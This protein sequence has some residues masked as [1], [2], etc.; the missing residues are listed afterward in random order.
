MSLSIISK[1]NTFKRQRDLV[2]QAREERSREKESLIDFASYR[3]R[4]IEFVQE[5][6]GVEYLTPEQKEFYVHIRDNQ[7]TNIQ[8]AHGVGKSF[9]MAGLVIWWVRAV[10]GIA[11]TTAPSHGQVKD[12][13]WKEVRFL[14]DRKKKILGG[15]RTELVLHFVNDKGKELTAIGFS[16]RNYDSNSFQGK[17]DEFLLLLQDEADGITQVIDDAYES[18]IQGSQ[19]RGVRIGNPLTP[20]SSFAKNCKINSIKVPVWNHVN[21][22]WA[23]HKVTLSNGKII[24]R[25]KTEIAALILKPATDKSAKSDP[26]KPQN[27]WP[28]SLPRDRIP[29]AVSIAWIE[30]IRAKYGEFSV[31]WVSRVEAEFPGD[32]V[33]GIIPISWLKQARQRYDN[34]PQYWD[35]LASLDRWRIGA[36]VGDGGDPH[37]ISL[38]RGCVLY[39]VKTYQGVNDRE[40]TVRLATKYIE[41]L[42][43]NLGGTYKGAVDR[44]GVGAGTLGTLRTHG[45]NFIGCTFGEKAKNEENY[46]D[47]KIELHW[48]LR[49]QLQKGEIAIAPLGEIEEELFEDLSAVR[50]ST[51]TKDKLICEPKKLTKARLGRSPNAGD[52][53]IISLEVPIQVYVIPE[54]VPASSNVD[55]EMRKIQQ[56]QSE[57]ENF[58]SV[59]EAEANQYFQ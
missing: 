19:N 27:Q 37:A 13:L 29:G 18:C 48:T 50:Y 26:V 36:D 5:V 53:L 49:E 59:T 55:L 43:N 21:V 4:P 3:M 6:L 35:N 31:Y 46:Q 24:H 44:T 42:V 17:H 56:L 32:D 25:L 15:R 52:S 8:A 7:T 14:Y 41:P 33:E 2:R 57:I 34:N 58:D 11:Y 47:R 28:E 1:I 16:T 23:Y 20:T 39:S 40:D 51:T 30:K 12:I 10:G 54:D 38:W 22:A 9:S 45:Y